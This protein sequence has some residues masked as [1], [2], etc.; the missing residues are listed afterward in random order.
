MQSRSTQISLVSS[1]C[2][3][4][5]QLSKS[6]FL[7]GLTIVLS[8]FHIVLLL[9]VL[10]SNATLGLALCQELLP[11][12]AKLLTDGNGLLYQLCHPLRLETKPPMHSQKYASE[13]I[14][15]IT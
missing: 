8:Y 15:S 12:E 4:L 2:I 5:L 14:Q 11:V 7:G 3:Q 1:A 9:L 10:N 13:L 6:L